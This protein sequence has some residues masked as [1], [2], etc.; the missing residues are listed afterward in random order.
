MSEISLGQFIKNVFDYS[1]GKMPAQQP[2]KVANENF[3]RAQNEA[4]K[5]VQ[6]TAQNI[7]NNMAR[8]QDILNTQMMLKQLTNVEQSWLMKHMFDFPENLTQLLEQIVTQGKSVT[9]K[10]LAALMAKELDADFL[11]ILTAVEKAAI[12]FGKPNEQWLDDISVEQANQYI[13]E[14]HFAPGSMLPKIQAAVDFASSKPGRQALITL[15]EK[16]KDGILGN[17]GTRIHL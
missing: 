12:N 7:A 6:Q 2:G 15:L 13:K 17:T 16:A 10:E 4:M 3:Q 9:G 5:M 1:T 11:I 8:Q 14:G